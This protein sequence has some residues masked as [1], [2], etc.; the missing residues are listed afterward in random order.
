MLLSSKYIFFQFIRKLAGCIQFEE[1]EEIPPYL[2][3]LRNFDFFQF[4]GKIPN[5]QSLDKFF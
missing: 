2:E 1:F 5:C 3:G 4:F